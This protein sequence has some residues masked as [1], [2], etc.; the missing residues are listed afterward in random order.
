MAPTTTNPGSTTTA[1]VPPRFQQGPI[2]TALNLGPLAPL[3][4]SWKG[5]GFNAM[6]RPD[7]PQSQ[8]IG[9]QT[10]RFLEL[11]LTSESFDFQ[12]IPG[13]VPTGV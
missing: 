7:N 1:A 8:P 5:S 10:K 3:V 4:G 9:G 11:N 12:T 6:W 13:V 2:T